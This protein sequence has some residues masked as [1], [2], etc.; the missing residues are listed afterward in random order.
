MKLGGNIIRPK[1]AVPGW[2]YLA[3]CVDNEHRFTHFYSFKTDIN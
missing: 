3:I 2:G 1:T